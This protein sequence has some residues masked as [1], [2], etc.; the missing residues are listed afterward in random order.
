MFNPVNCSGYLI[1]RLSPETHK[2]FTDGRFDIFGDQFVWDEWAASR[3]IE[4]ANWDNIA[5]E[6]AGFTEREGRR[7]RERCQSAGW[8]DILDRW[9]INF[10]IAERPWGLR[11]KLRASGQWES[12][13]H[14]IKPFDRQEGY[15]VFVRRTDSNRELIRRCQ[16]YSEQ[17]R[18]LERG[19]F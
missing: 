17:M 13:F 16:R 3:G 6:K 5:W 9:Q 1:W 19:R 4:R 10:V 14:W 18:F 11:D 8:S 15:E 7:I 12:V 2:V